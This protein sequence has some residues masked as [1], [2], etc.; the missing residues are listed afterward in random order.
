MHRLR[1]SGRFAALT[2]L[3]ALATLGLHL[4]IS[5]AAAQ[6]FSMPSEPDPHTPEMLKA[7]NAVI[8][9]MSPVTQETLSNPGPGDW[10]NW[11]RNYAGWGYSPL[12]QINKSNVGKLD[13]A[14][15]WSLTNGQAGAIPIV[16][17]GVMFVQNSGDAVQALN[18]A[19]GDVFWTYKPRYGRGVRPIMHRGMAIYE[20]KLFVPASNGH[21]VA[22]DTKSGKVLW[23]HEITTPRD[24][25]VTGVPLVV[26]GKVIFG[27]SNCTASRCFILALDAET[28]NEVWRFYT[29]PTHDMPGGNTWNDL[30]DNARFGGSVWTGASYDPDLNMLYIG[31]G[32]PYPWSSTV[33]GTYPAVNKPGITNTLLYTDNTLALDPDTGKLIWNH[34]H[35]PNDSWDLDYVFE[36][37]IVTLPVD[38]KKRKLVV[39]SGKMAIIEALD[40][41][42]GQFVF[43]KDMGIQNVVTAMDPKTGAKTYDP[44]LIP[45]PGQTVKICPH[46]G[47]ARNWPGFGFDPQNDFLYMPMQW[48]CGEYTPYPREGSDPPTGGHAGWKVLPPPNSDGHI[49]RLA[50]V[51]LTNRDTAWEHRDRAAQSSAS[52]PTAGGLLFQGTNGRYF[53]AFDANSG[54]ILWQVRLNNKVSSFPVTYMVDGQQYV[55]VIATSGGPNAGSWGGLTPDVDAPLENASTVWV[56]KLPNQ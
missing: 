36:R 1:V 17:D 51:N 4:T 42:T 30:P 37:Q 33:R 19:N 39:T 49:G 31:V 15:S 27:K 22:L 28:G 46:G 44:K 54:K 21:M 56:F 23:D 3:A 16:H 35:L 24:G 18:A 32:Q 26:H 52:L 41:K 47:G 29:V 48:H 55:A 45:A 13:L 50:A 8:E 10:V 43:S 34:P 20:N 53:R 5:P 2:G 38:G 6:G 9:K 7:K 11:R 14:W 40:A 25:M 12:D